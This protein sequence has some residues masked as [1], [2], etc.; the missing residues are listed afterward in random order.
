MSNT[1]QGITNQT[2]WVAQNQDVKSLKI[3][4][5]NNKS[6]NNNN[7]NE[8]FE[9]ED[10]SC[11]ARKALPNMSECTH[12]A[13]NPV[14]NPI[15]TKVTYDDPRSK[16]QGSWYKSEPMLYKTSSGEY[17][18]YTPHCYH[19]PVTHAGQD[20]KFSEAQI[21]TGAYRY[22]GFN[23]ALDSSKVMPIDCYVKNCHF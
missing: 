4:S 14:F 13:G 1:E 21:A 5:Q 16:E 11:P 23:T 17:G 15:Y 7:N 10:A 18:K 3:K 9:E 2:K 20:T 6:Q 12:L 22:N 19:M 8:D